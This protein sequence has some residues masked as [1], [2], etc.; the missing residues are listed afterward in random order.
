MHERQIFLAVFLR[1]ILALNFSILTV[2]AAPSMGATL[3]LGFTD[4]FVATVSRP[5]ALAFTP[6]GRLLI[7][8]QPGQLRVY[9][10]GSLLPSPALDLS[11][12][13]RICTN[14]ERGLM[15]VAVDPDFTTTR[16][17]FVYYTYR[18][19]AQINACRNRVSR[20]TLSDAN[21]TSDELKLIDNVPLSGGFHN[22]GD[23]H[24]GKDGYL[25]ISVGDGGTDYA[26][27]SGSAAE[28][29][30]SRDRHVLLGKLLRITKTGAIPA[31]NPFRGAD[32]ARCH[33]TGRTTVGKICQETF[34]WG[35]RNPFRFALDPNASVTRFYI[36]DVG[37]NYWEEINEAVAGSDYGWNTREGNCPTGQY[38]GCGAPPPGMTN[39]IHAYPHTTG[40]TA[41]TSGAFVPNGAWTPEYDGAYLYGDYN[42]AKIFRLIPLG[43]GGFTSVEFARGLTSSTPTTMIF[44]PFGARQALYYSSYGNGGQ[45]R[46]IAY[47][48]SSNRAPVAVSAATPRFGA[49]PLDVTFDG[50]ASS[51][52][53]GDALTY[54]W[55][56][57]DGSPI[58]TGR[59]VTHSYTQEGKF[60][61][62]LT[63]NDGKGG[64]ASMVLRVDP[65]HTP[66]QPL[67]I[68]PTTTTR[69]RVGELLT[70][71]GSAVDELGNPLPDSAL[72]WSINLH[73]N[74]HTH[75]FLPATFGNNIPIVTP[76]PED[77]AATLTSYL[78]IQLTVTDS[79]GLTKSIFQRLNA[80]R[81]DLSFATNPPG[82][83][84]QLNG[85][86]TTTPTTLTSWEGYVINANAPDQ[87]TTSGNRTFESWS[88]GGAQTHSIITPPSPSSY[89]ATF[90]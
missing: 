59:A 72:R 44:G 27:D 86:D 34:V 23:L 21:T 79:R 48:G 4:S 69:F 77:L 50:G 37:Q 66:P 54:Q 89:T 40:C 6:D 84:L 43:T 53:D 22:S 76:P 39:P 36:N 87:S 29:D 80:R 90:E 24:F 20:F 5:T 11:I 60:F 58:V 85:A 17:I 63:V 7:T 38:T 30:A 41:I 46:R 74:T 71:R 12:G 47:T 45:I 28:N 83:Q 70:L 51:D 65:G 10:N 19:G 18:F 8:T 42:C 82:L 88:D 14:S 52:P 61:P 35:L 56:F 25:Y 33:I 81:V 57:G 31:D 55:N 13:D 3:P 15:G 2:G 16:Y 49:L 62:R 1:I 9:R 73:H 32:S 64:V 26:G 78:N 67:I 75:P 68:S